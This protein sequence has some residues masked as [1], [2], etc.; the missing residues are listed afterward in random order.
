MVCGYP[1]P[2]PHH[3]LVAD[4]AKQTVT[5]PIGK[6]ASVTLPAEAAGHVGRITKALHKENKQQKKIGRAR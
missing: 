2:C 3:T 6:G 5:V 4:V 1:L